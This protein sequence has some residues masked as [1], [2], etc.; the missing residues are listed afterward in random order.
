[1]KIWDEIE[2]LI[3]EVAESHRLSLLKMG[4]RIIPN[5]TP[6]DILQP[7]DYPELDAHPEFRYEEGMLAG[8]HSL[9][10]A[11]AVLKK[12]QGERCS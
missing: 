11:L 5:L 4:R 7:N 3:D 9:Q 2:T 12:Q 1:M 6:E 10:I 8:I